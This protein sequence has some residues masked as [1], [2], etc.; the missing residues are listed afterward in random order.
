MLLSTYLIQVIHQ[1]IIIFKSCTNLSWNISLPDVKMC[2]LG[3]KLMGQ[4]IFKSCVSGDISLHFLF[5]TY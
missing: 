2:G 5:F 1:V 3:R 4:N